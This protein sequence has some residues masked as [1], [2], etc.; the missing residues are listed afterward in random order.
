MTKK[1]QSP[2][3]PVQINAQVLRKDREL[4]NAKAKAANLNSSQLIQ[5]LIYTAEVISKPDLNADIQKLNAWLGR[6]NSNINM[7]AKWANIYKDKCDSE[8][9]LY[10]LSAIQADV[11]EVAQYT[12][13]LRAQ[14]FGKRRKKRAEK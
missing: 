6:I 4:L 8:L 1:E 9:I 12:Q 10:R 7:L 5:R 13:D 11:R 3:D 2:D 14:G